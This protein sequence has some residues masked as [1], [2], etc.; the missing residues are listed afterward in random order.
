MQVISRPARAGSYRRGLLRP[1]LLGAG[2]SLLLALASNM[3]GSPYGPRAAGLW[4]LA[5]SGRSLQWQG[6]QLP[7]LAQPADL[8]PGVGRGHLLVIALAVLGVGLLGFA[9][10]QVWRSVRSQPDLRLGSLWWV[11]ALWTA[12]LLLAAPFASQDVWIYGAQG[13]LAT[14]GLGASYPVQHLGHS[15]WLAGVDHKYINLPWIYG[16]GALDLSAL[17]VLISGGH[18]WVAA[19]LWRLSA[20]AGLVM[21]AWGVNRVASVRGSNGAS[22]VVAAVANPGVLIIGVASI[23]NDAL[24]VGFMVAGIALAVSKRPWFGLALAATAVTIKAPAVLAV[25]AIAWWGWGTGWHVRL[26]GVLAGAVLAIGALAVTG[27]FV[28]GGFGWIRS[29]SLAKAVSSFSLLGGVYGFES[30]RIV[31][32]I[33]F[34]GV[35]VGVILVVALKHRENWVRVLALGLGVM[36]VCAVNPQPWYLLWVVPVLG[37][38]VAQNLRGWTTI[39]V[40]SGIMAWAEMPLGTIIWFVL[41]VVPRP[42]PLPGPEKSRLEPLALAEGPLVETRRG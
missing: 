36:A 25:V 39:F 5:M 18:Q 6:P 10:V 23:H 2:G 34:I 29:A 40:L 42:K 38:A 11:F 30:S 4:P 21:C 3:P 33:Q 27:L 7:W 9:W 35:V 8:G 37:C 1:A 22:A 31:D 16:P 19:E 14:T 15:A 28:G 20:V 13:K 12:P 26:R 32:L 41:I 17:F 24:M